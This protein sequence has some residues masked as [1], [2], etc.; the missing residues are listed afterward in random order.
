M[1]A[2][3]VCQLCSAP[4]KM[5][6][7]SALMLQH[8]PS[9]SRQ[10]IPIPSCS[11][12]RDR[13]EAEYAQHI[14]EERRLR[15]I[16]NF[17][18]IQFSDTS[19]PREFAMPH[20]LWEKPEEE[21][22]LGNKYVI[23]GPSGTG[24]TTYL[25]IICLKLSA[26]GVVIRGGSTRDVMDGLKD[27]KEVDARM[28]SLKS[29]QVLVLDDLDAVSTRYEVDRLYTLISHYMQPGFSIL[30]SSNTSMEKLRARLFKSCNYEINE[31]IEALLSRL[32]ERSTMVI[33]S[34]D[35]L[36]RRVVVTVVREDADG[37]PL[38]AGKS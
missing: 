34:P 10:D 3:Q 36:D 8:I 16:A 29:G 38:K 13:A 23:V 32:S 35:A 30:I 1:T 22:V 6:T 12:L 25:K 9:D 7:P 17:K 33:Q 21:L 18:H 24:K 27:M 11:C 20:G 2:S 37:N 14:Q 5:W 15:V 19:L 4:Y 26:R 28:D 31:K